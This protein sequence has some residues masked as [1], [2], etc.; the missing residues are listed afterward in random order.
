M[1]MRVA[2]LVLSHKLL[3]YFVFLPH[4]ISGNI[5]HYQ[6]LKDAA[7]SKNTKLA[8]GT[9]KFVLV[10][11]LDPVFAY[12]IYGLRGHIN[13]V[14]FHETYIGFDCRMYSAALMNMYDQ[15]KQGGRKGSVRNYWGGGGLR[16]LST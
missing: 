10:L 12:Q 14:N 7:V 4:L 16:Y 3:S 11:S 6:I 1:L 2:E 13:G 15:I 9:P 5:V 8:T